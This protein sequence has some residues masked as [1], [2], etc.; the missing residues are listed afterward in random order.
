MTRFLPLV[1]G[2]TL[3]ACGGERQQGL[4]SDIDRSLSSS[5]SQVAAQP[6]PRLQTDRLDSV[7][8]VLDG[9]NVL[10]IDRYRFLPI[11]SI[12]S[13]CFEAEQG[14]ATLSVCLARS[15]TSGVAW[16]LHREYR[17]PGAPLQRR[18]YLLASINGRLTGEGIELHVTSA[19]L[20]VLEDD[21]NVET[22][23]KDL[24]SLYRPISTTVE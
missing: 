11:T 16:V 6:I 12:V 23:A 3:L 15:A 24:W 4:G 8:E 18:S 2:L 13:G 19:G 14:G 22:M 1:C 5:D 7:R 20:L 9:T 21:S 10:P 17:E